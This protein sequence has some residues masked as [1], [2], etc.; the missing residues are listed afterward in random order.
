MG[1]PWTRTAT[2]LAAAQAKAEEII[3]R[4]PELRE[5]AAKET[6]VE[7]K[8]RM[9]PLKT[10]PYRGERFV[11]QRLIS[12]GPWHVYD[13]KTRQYLEGYRDRKSAARHAKELNQNITG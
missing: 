2:S 5:L 3:A 13:K 12:T 1:T 4:Y 7:R 6:K 11:S 9:N 10:F 8:K